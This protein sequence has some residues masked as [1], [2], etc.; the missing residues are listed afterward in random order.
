MEQN[1]SELH[2]ERLPGQSC[3]CSS[4]AKLAGMVTLA[5]IELHTMILMQPT[6]I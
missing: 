4:G 5:M 6:P 3:V 2:D 1:S